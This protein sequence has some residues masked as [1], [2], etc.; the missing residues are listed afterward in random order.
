MYDAGY[1]LRADGGISLPLT[2]EFRRAVWRVFMEAVYAR[3]I[4]KAQRFLSH[5]K[6][7]VPLFSKTLAGTERL[8]K[9]HRPIVG[10]IRKATRRREAASYHIEEALMNAADRYDPNYILPRTGKPVKFTNW[11]ALAARGAWRFLDRD[12]LSKAESLDAP[13]NKPRDDDSKD[14]TLAD[15]V[16]EIEQRPDQITLLDAYGETATARSCESWKLKFDRNE[17]TAALNE[18]QRVVFDN[19]SLSGKALAD[20]I[21]VSEP[22]VSQLRAETLEAL[23]KR[24]K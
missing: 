4:R 20:K 17:V 18:N 22:R 14:Q 19:W 1:A 6:L 13:I 16:A 2:S 15:M 23:I 10:I 3:T 24:S 5:G 12:V 7:V 11:I 8:L 9:D 21:G